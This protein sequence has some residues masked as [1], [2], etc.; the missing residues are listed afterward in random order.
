MPKLR[1]VTHPPRFS[2]LFLL[3]PRFLLLF[4]S[5]FFGR[6]FARSMGLALG[7]MHLFVEQHGASHLFW[8][9]GLADWFRVVGWLVSR[10]G[11]WDG[12][13]PS[14]T[15]AHFHI[16]LS[17]LHILTHSRAHTHTHTHTTHREAFP[18]YPASLSRFRSFPIPTYLPLSPGLVFLCYTNKNNLGR[19]G[20][21]SGLTCVCVLHHT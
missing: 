16:S 4:F 19:P 6:L 3:V 20:C 18:L 10:Q 14:K 11:V 9:V 2:F 1:H 17:H 12:A 21:S 13:H 15:L 8:A 5:L 7:S